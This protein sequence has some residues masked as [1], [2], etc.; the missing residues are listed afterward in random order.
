ME[1][2]EANYLKVKNNKD[3][4]E[5]YLESQE[6]CDLWW[7][8][9][10]TV[11][12]GDYVFYKYPDLSEIEFTNWETKEKLYFNVLEYSFDYGETWSKL[13]E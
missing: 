12:A 5:Y 13:G 7:N 2:Y 4:K 6:H 9:N 11:I 10:E 8:T 1:I 3:G